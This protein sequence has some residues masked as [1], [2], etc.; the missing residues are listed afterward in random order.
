MLIIPEQD[1]LVFEARVSPSEIDQL[2]IGQTSRIQ[3]RAF[4]PGRHV[5]LNGKVTRI[6]PLTI[7]WLERLAV[8]MDISPSVLIASE[9]GILRRTSHNTAKCWPRSKSCAT[10]LRRNCKANTIKGATAP[11]L[12]PPATGR[13][14]RAHARPFGPAKLFLNSGSAVDRRQLMTPLQLGSSTR[15]SVGVE[16]DS[17]PQISAITGPNEPNASRKAGSVLDADWGSTLRAV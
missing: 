4:D 12:L 6:S 11:F 8:A 17:A 1:E 9:G 2:Q 3:L 14:T 10:R 15:K 7:D 5:S 13:E 16:P